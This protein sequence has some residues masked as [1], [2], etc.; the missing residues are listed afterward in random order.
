M[1]SIVLCWIWTELKV[2]SIF[3]MYS[4]WVKQV[5]TSGGFAY[6]SPCHNSYQKTSSVGSER[7]KGSHC[8][9]R[10][11]EAKYWNLPTKIRQA[12]DCLGSD[13]GSWWCELVM[14]QPTSRHLVFVLYSTNTL[15]CSSHCSCMPHAVRWD[16]LC[17]HLEGEKTVNP[18]LLYPSDVLYQ[19]SAATTPSLTTLSSSAFHN[20]VFRLC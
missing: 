11:T 20:T 3:G 16:Y 14:T 2:T 17:N 13:R 4:A 18:T 9:N 1:S 7:L 8:H 10:N 5:Q 6:Y 12:E 19:I 15:R